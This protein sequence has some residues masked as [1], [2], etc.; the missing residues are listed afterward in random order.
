[1]GGL[2]AF[3]VPAGRPR[4]DGGA[5]HRVLQILPV[6]PQLEDA[7]GVVARHDV[8]SRVPR[9]LRE[10]DDRHEEVAL[11]PREDRAVGLLRVLI[12]RELCERALR[13]LPRPRRRLR[14]GRIALARSGCGQACESE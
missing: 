11:T 5:T 12:V 1:M 3:G 9:G 10:R 2:S 7:F 6:G 13:D 4:F 14:G 8:I